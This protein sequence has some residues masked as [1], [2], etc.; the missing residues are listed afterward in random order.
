MAG[1]GGGD[2]V[3][4]YEEEVFYMKKKV[5]VLQYRLMMKDEQ[6]INSKKAEEDL[7]NRVKELDKCFDDEAERCRENTAEMSRQYKEMQE[8]FNDRIG[9]LQKE[10]AKAKE[11]IEAVTSDIE[12]VR[13]EKDEII[14]SKDS[15]IKSLSHNMETMAFEF[16]DMLQ[17][18]LHKMGQR[19][20]V[21]H[22]S[23]DRDATQKPLMNR[24]KEFS[25]TND[26]AQEQK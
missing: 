1:R 23:W 5:E 18:T 15:E 12:R 10:V 11:E 6:T 16:A 22:N 17:E 26:V 13:I 3:P 4:H 14:R 8:S 21:T 24:L 9:A 7:R 19:I 25:L 20:E 2:E